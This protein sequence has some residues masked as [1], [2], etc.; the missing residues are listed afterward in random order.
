MDF[1]TM[2][3]TELSDLID[4]AKCELVRRQNLDVLQRDLNLVIQQ[5]RQEGTIITPE[6]GGE[7]QEGI[8]YG[9]GDITTHSGKTWR[10]LTAP[11][12]WEPGVAAWRQVLKDGGPA[13]FKQ[14]VSSVDAYQQGEQATFKG[15]TFRSRIPA[16]VWSPEVYPDGWER[17][18]PAEPAPPVE[19]GGE[20]G[21]DGEPDEPKEPGEPSAPVW[22]GN[23]HSYAVGD[24]VEFNGSVYRVLQ[25]HV[26]QPAWN[27]GVVPSLYQ[28]V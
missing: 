18:D 24:L 15:E 14:P 13:A 28:L 19:P 11:N 5:H 20:T 12:T 9:I 22:D 23:G 4:S 26:S 3:P 2:T 21:S 7:W 16:N 6:P 10:S 25:G 27:P 8:L 17:V 1:Q